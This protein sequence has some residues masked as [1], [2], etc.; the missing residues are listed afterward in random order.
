VILERFP[1]PFIP[2]RFPWR[3]FERATSFYR[4]RQAPA[5]Q[6]TNSPPLDQH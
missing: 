5:W 2:S 3:G 4:E 1:Q 6:N